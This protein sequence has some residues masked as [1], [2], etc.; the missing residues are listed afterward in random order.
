M[1]FC[2]NEIHALIYVMQFGRMD[3][4]DQDIM[5]LIIGNCFRITKCSGQRVI[6]VV[7]HT[8]KNYITN[9]EWAQDWILDQSR[10]QNSLLHQFVNLSENFDLAISRIHLVNCKNPS[11]EEESGKQTQL[12]YISN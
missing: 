12:K 5:K 4:Q 9:L 7:T 11:D 3:N 6:V 2:R 10:D 1:F 8:P